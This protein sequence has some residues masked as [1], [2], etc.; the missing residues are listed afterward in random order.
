LNKQRAFDSGDTCQSRAVAHYDTGGEFVESPARAGEASDALS[1]RRPI[2][3][4]GS[5]LRLVRRIVDVL[6]E[7]D[8][9]GGPVC[10]LFAG[11]GTV[12]RA[13]S[14]SRAVVSVDIQEYSRVLCTALLHPSGIDAEVVEQ[15]WLRARASGH[16]GR[17]RRAV[18]PLA[19]YEADCLREAARGDFEPLCDLL[20]HGS[21]IA[22]EQDA[23]GAT[24]TKLREALAETSARL[25]EAGLARGPAAL[26]TRH[27]GGIYF[28]FAQAAQFDA[29]LEAIWG[30]PPA[31]RDSFLAALLSTASEVVNTVGKQFAQPLRPRASDGRPKRNLYQL[32]ARDRFADVSELYESWLNRYL[33]VPR[34]R[35]P[36]RVLRMDYAEALENLKGEVSVVYADPPYTRDHY[37]RFYHVL[38]TLCL[39]DDPSVSTVRVGG[40]ERISRGFY[41]VARH[42]SPFCIKSQAPRA[43]SKLFEKARGLDVPLVV[44]YSPYARQS[45]A[46]PRLLTMSELEQLA[47]QFYRRVDIR[48]AGRVAHNK[49]NHAT[50][51]VGV[52]YD[53][54]ALVVC[55]P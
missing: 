19:A 55:E 20:E 35:R 17:L 53:A 15:F 52:T 46:R 31:H 26:A 16:T 2:H 21:L 39:R 33:S 8:A 45:G 37:S 36:H 24:H 29:L 6:D 18:E 13:L 10:D 38:E 32:A 41:R 30:L 1:I 47:R 9:S 23:C 49:L 25:A 22:L 11:S 28:S 12:S 50:K 7:L 54:E 3:Y 4:L 43:F 51:N 40:R 44:S 5:K 34:P 42:Q 27:Y 48:H 14:E